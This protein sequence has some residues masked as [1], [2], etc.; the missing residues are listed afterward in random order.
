M[1]LAWMNARCSSSERNELVKGQTCGP[2]L[3]R[4][5]VPAHSVE[6]HVSMLGTA[7][8]GQGSANDHLAYSGRVPA[9]AER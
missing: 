4:L 8:M 2:Q 3:L 9:Y 1:Y 5:R 7:L 6:H